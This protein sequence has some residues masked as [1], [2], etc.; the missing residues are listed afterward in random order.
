MRN[1]G[2]KVHNVMK[3]TGIHQ[4]V[5]AISKATGKDCGCAHRQAKLNRFSNRVIDK[6]IG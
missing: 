3:A 5:K 4:T 6:L 2:D 1:L